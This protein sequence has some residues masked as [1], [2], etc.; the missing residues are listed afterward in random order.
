MDRKTRRPRGF[1]KSHRRVGAVAMKC[2]MTREWDTNGVAIPLTVLWLDENRVVQVKSGEERQDKE[3]LFGIQVGAGA[4]RHKRVNKS[5]IGHFRK[6]LPKGKAGKA[7]EGVVVS[8]KVVEFEVT[9][10]CLLAPGTAIN[11][12]HF[13]VGQFVDV[14]GTTKGKGFAGGMKRHGMKGGPA[15]HGTTKAHRTIGSTGQC[16]DPGKVFKGKKMPGRMGGKTR[17][18]QRL[19]VYKVDPVHNLVYIK[20]QVPGGKGAY[21]RITDSK[22]TFQDVAL[23]FPTRDPEEAQ[24]GNQVSIAYAGTKNDPFTRYWQF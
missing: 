7:G 1:P 23:P 11:A 4:R 6:H 24:T 13:V 8:R 21:V 10:N 20:G 17:T 14:Q 16:Q 15:S 19:L 5:L 22:I 3:N 2:G 9:E 18:Q 12:D